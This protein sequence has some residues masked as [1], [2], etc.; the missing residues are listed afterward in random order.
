MARAW[1]LRARRVGQEIR[2]ARCGARRN[3][4]ASR[5]MGK[6]AAK[7]ND[8]IVSVDTHILMVPSPGGPVPTPTPMPFNG[9][10]RSALSP[11]VMIENVAAATKGS[12]ADNTPPH[13]P[14]AGPFQSPPSNK[15]TIK[16][17]SSTVMINNKPAAHLGDPAD[18]CNDPPDQPNG[19]VIGTA[20]TVLERD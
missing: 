6:P 18:T 12:V 3:V 17:G 5:P 1:L 19:K 4:K 14:T 13:L 16:D 9:I 15:A 8:K 20:A 2:A 7:Q 11:D 10:L